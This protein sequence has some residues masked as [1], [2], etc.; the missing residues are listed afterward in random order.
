MQDIGCF[1]S[2][3]C[4]LQQI[5]LSPVL[6]PRTFIKRSFLRVGEQIPRS[7][8]FTMGQD[9]S[10]SFKQQDSCL[11][12][13]GIYELSAEPCL[14]RH[15][16]LRLSSSRTGLLP[17]KVCPSLSK[18]QVSN[19]CCPPCLQCSSLSSA[20]APSYS[21]AFSSNTAPSTWPSVTTFIYRCPFYHQNNL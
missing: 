13:H 10:P 3:K 17:V 8:L 18:P 12:F 7:P 4:G 14:T 16:I 2:D 6:K 15:Y 11:H 20:K 19:I 5:I 21:S 9:T 1:N